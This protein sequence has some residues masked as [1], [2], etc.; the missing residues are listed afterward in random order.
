MGNAPAKGPQQ[1]KYVHWDQAGKYVQFFSW[2]HHVNYAFM[3]GSIVV[4]GVV[5]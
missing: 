3:R 2:H 5:F 1:K 4:Y